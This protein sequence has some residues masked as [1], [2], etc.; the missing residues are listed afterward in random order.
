MSKLH[1]FRN[2]IH[3]M[4]GEVS[5]FIE[6]SLIPK[7]SLKLAVSICL[8]IVVL[9]F[10]QSCTPSMENL[11]CLPINFPE[12]E[13]GG[14]ESYEVQ[15]YYVEIPFDTVLDFYETS[16]IPVDF[17]YESEFGRWEMERIDGSQVLLSCAAQV[18]TLEMESGCIYIRGEG[19]TTLIETVWYISGDAAPWCEPDLSVIR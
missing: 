11:A 13:R 7:T 16:L 9:L 2:R 17:P 14:R 6:L 18:N 4:T 15:R 1:T 10:W 3:S 19:Y 12:Q 5:H 8:F